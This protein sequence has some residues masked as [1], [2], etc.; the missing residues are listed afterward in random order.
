MTGSER[1]RTWLDWAQQGDWGRAEV[2][3]EL[4]GK[5]P[6]AALSTLSRLQAALRARRYHAALA[7]VQAL[8]EAEAD[9]QPFLA[10]PLPESG[11]VQAA[12]EQLQQ[13]LRGGEQD[14]SQALACSLTRPE[15]LNLQGRLRAEAGDVEAAA[16]CFREALELDPGHYRALTNLGN[17]ELEAGNLSGA[18][19][20]YR[21]AL[22]MEESESALHNLGVVLSKQGRRGES[23]RALRQAETLRRRRQEEEVRAAVQRD[24]PRLS[25]VQRWWPWLVGALL[26]LGLLWGA[27]QL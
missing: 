15:A 6:L 4:S 11:T 8:S 3:S 22:A 17:L 19:A 1:P 16:Q 7:A 27:A 5:G 10:G 23:V 21:R 25:A 2:A 12:V 24:I 9:L 13:A 18:E 14:L 26:V 20:H